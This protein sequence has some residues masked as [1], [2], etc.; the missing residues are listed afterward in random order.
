[1][2]AVKQEWWRTLKERRPDIAEL[3]KD[4]PDLAKVL[5]QLRGLVIDV[6][7]RTAKE[8]EEAQRL[9]SQ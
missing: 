1:V 7:Y 9:S 3:V 6:E 5:F 4:K 2:D 8:I